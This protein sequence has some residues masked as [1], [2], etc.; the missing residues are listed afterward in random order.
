[1]SRV[2]L[3]K[4]IVVF[5]FDGVIC[6]STDECMVTS[7]NAWQEWNGRAELRESPA[8]FSAK[9]MAEF[10]ALRP[11]VRGAGEYLVLFHLLAQGK[12]N[13][14]QEAFETEVDLH[15]DNFE[16]FKKIFFKHRKRLRAISLV[17]WLDLHVVYPEVISFLSEINAKSA[18]YIATLKD[19]ESVRLILRQHGLVLPEK[20]F[21][22]QAQI[23]SKLQALNS[24]RNI[25]KCSHSEIIFVDD[26]ITHLKEPS[27]A[28][29]M[30][31][32]AAW[33]GCLPE[34]VNLAKSFNIQS[35]HSVSEIML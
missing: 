7:W 35:I 2:K 1:M 26:N 11:R 34:F 19:G 16:D 18:L 33:C 14:T 15:R 8:S 17:K 31:Y 24:I 28:G 23:S 29:Y 12:I 13:V 3:N 10:R 32:H 20:K 5:D 9:M 27:D 6:D 25:E 4:K 30:V 21:Y 22:D